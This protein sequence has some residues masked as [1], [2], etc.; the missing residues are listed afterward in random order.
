MTILKNFTTETGSFVV[1]ICWRYLLNFGGTFI[2]IQTPAILQHNRFLMLFRFTV[3]YITS[4]LFQII[5]LNIFLFIIFYC[6]F[7]KSIIL[8]IASILLII[9]H[10]FLLLT[11]WLFFISIAASLKSAP[12]LFRD[13]RFSWIL[14]HDFWFTI[15][16]ASPALSHLTWMSKVMHINQGYLA[17]WWLW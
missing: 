13:S 3:S 17:K 4:C 9:V 6:W 12:S 2:R 8:P 7:D 1:I 11:C 15:S 16:L 10:T 14:G 5:I